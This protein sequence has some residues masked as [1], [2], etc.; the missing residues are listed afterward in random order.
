MLYFPPLLQQSISH[1]QSTATS[2]SLVESGFTIYCSNLTARH[3]LYND[4]SSITMNGQVV[5][6]AYCKILNLAAPTIVWLRAATFYFY[7]LQSSLLNISKLAAYAIAKCTSRLED[8]YSLKLRPEKHRN[9][10][11]SRIS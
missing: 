5:C 2:K 4:N 10:S 6:A 7:H 8:K 9:C 1:Y 3:W 11:G